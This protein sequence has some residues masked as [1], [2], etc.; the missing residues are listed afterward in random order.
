MCLR[1]CDKKRATCSFLPLPPPTHTPSRAEDFHLKV[2]RAQAFRLQSTLYRFP[3]D[4]AEKLISITNVEWL[5]FPAPERNVN[6]GGPGAG[7][8][9]PATSRHVVPAHSHMWYR[10]SHVQRST[11]THAAHTR[12]LRF[13]PGLGHYLACV[14]LRMDLSL[15]AGLFSVHFPASG[16]SGDGGP[17]SVEHL[18]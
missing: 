9:E 8:E 7:D 4:K 12:R 18:Q 11:H 2:A 13:R 3:K 5:H 16:S 14:M 10:H 17:T 6:P 1:N 15:S